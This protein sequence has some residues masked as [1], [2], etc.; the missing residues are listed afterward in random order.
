M[1]RPVTTLI[2]PERLHEV[3]NI[4]ARLRNG[5]RI[6]HYETVRRRKDGV[7][8][9]NLPDGLPREKDETGKIISASKIARDITDRKRAQV[10]FSSLLLRN[11][12]NCVNRSVALSEIYDVALTTICRCQ[13]RTARRHSFI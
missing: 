2:P 4:L 6:E 10:R 13:I 11:G 8:I 1:G 9:E 7:E 12:Q 3:P 5:D